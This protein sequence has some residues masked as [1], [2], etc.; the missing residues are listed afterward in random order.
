[1]RRALRLATLVK[2]LC[3]IVVLRCLG[4]A[5]VE[6]SNPF[7]GFFFFIKSLIEVENEVD[8]GRL[9]LCGNPFRGLLFISFQFMLGKECQL[10][11]LV[12]SLVVN[13]SES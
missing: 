5:K 4:K 2:C 6:G 1:M 3:S 13:K 12:A 11:R 8:K 7:R 10:L 9:P